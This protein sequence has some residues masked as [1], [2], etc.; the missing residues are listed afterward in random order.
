MPVPWN[1]FAILVIVTIDNAI[2]AGILATTISGAQRLTALLLTGGFLAM[3]QIL[4]GLGVGSLLQHTPFQILL[5]VVLSW[6]SIRTLIGSFGNRNGRRFVWTLVK[7]VS[8]TT[9]GSLDN[10]LWLGVEFQQPLSLLFL[11]SL[12]TIPLFL[13]VSSFLANQNDRHHWILI[14]GSGLMA[15]TAGGLY[16]HSP[17]SLPRLLQPQWLVQVAFSLLI[18]TLGWMLRRLVQ[19][20]A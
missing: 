3:A 13:V 8:Y 5:I 11:F 6:M 1:Q 17:V 4:L 15:W 12:V 10:L 14:A 7:V 16:A 20:A 19:Y 18:L 2:L 9:L